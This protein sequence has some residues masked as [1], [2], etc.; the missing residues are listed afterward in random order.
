MMTMIHAEGPGLRVLSSERWFGPGYCGICGD[1]GDA[2]VARA[3]RFWC[4]D[5]GWKM[6]VLCIHCGQ[7]AA[8]R[9][10][11]PDDYASVVREDAAERIDVTADMGDLDGAYS[12]SEGGGA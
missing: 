6:G 2:L 4:P 12:D 5:D 7:E 3:V 10:P 8:A 9:G 1:R 11:R